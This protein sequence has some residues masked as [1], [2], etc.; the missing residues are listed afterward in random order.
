MKKT[1][2]AVLAVVTFCFSMAAQA[3]IG[4]C[5]KW[6]S[7]TD[8]YN[9]RFQASAYIGGRMTEI[10]GRLYQDSD[11]L[12]LTDA[13]R[14]GVKNYVNQVNQEIIADCGFKNY[15]CHVEHYTI[16]INQ[17]E[18]YEAKKKSEKKVNATSAKANL[19]SFVN[20]A[21]AAQRPTQVSPEERALMERVNKAQKKLD[22]IPTY[23]ADNEVGD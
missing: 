19:G 5:G 6:D 1:L 17:L 15:E 4:D 12:G 8:R 22:A 13:E 3:E 7:T 9:C 11:N 10:A 20:T 2:F 16:A 23:N 18:A 21:P 14:V